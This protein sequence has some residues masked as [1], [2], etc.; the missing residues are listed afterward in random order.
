MGT[1]RPSGLR[2]EGFLLRL[3]V[4]AGEVD[5][6]VEVAHEPLP[7][8]EAAEGLELLAAEVLEAGPREDAAG[9]GLDGLGPGRGEPL[10]APRAPVPEKIP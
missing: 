7:V 5:L 1:R 2:E 9:E 6:P 8:G 4:D 3:V 10:E